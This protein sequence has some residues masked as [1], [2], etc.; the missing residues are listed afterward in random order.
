MMT[1][2]RKI[3]LFRYLQVHS[4]FD[5]E[6]IKS[7][8]RLKDD[9]KE[10]KLIPINRFG[11]NINENCIFTL[12]LPDPTV[13]D[14]S[15]RLFFLSLHSSCVTF[16]LNGIKPVPILDVGTSLL[17]KRTTCELAH[18][19]KCN[20]E[21]KISESFNLR[22]YVYASLEDLTPSF[23]ERKY[24][25]SP[26]LNSSFDI[27]MLDENPLLSFIGYSSNRLSRR[28]MYK[29][30]IKIM[31]MHFINS[32]S[33]QWTREKI[34]S[35]EY[36]INKAIKLIYSCIQSKL[37]KNIYL[38]N[39]KILHLAWI[40]QIDKKV[41]FKKRYE[42]TKSSTSINHSFQILDMPT[43]LLA[44]EITLI[45]TNLFLSLR[46]EELARL[47]F[48]PSSVNSITCPN[49]CQL[50]KFYLKI[51]HLVS[52]QIVQS[53]LRKQRVKVILKVIEWADECYKKNNKHSASA[54]ISGLLSPPVVRLKATWR[55]LRE[56]Y[57]QYIRKLEEFQNISHCLQDITEIPLLCDILNV[58]RA[59]SQYRP[60]ETWN[61]WKRPINIPNRISIN[62][63]AKRSAECEISKG[64][65]MER[66]V[67][68]LINEETEEISHTISKPELSFQ[69]IQHSP[70]CTFNLL[71]CCARY[72]K[73]YN[74][75]YRRI[76]FYLEKLH[77]KLTLYKI[78]SDSYVRNF[79]L[80]SK[81][82][83][84]IWKIS[85]ES[86]PPKKHDC[87][88]NS[89]LLDLTK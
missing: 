85:F 73:S 49:L 75:T 25:L 28:L 72:P 47:I 53:N 52:Y 12:S 23:I 63:S 48:K 24:Y 19:R 67:Q 13:P 69:R 20:S 29:D 40:N 70:P 39:N 77:Y 2:L 14:I 15:D 22:S 58:Y 43:K 18:L 57:P 41:F 37:E 45:D 84:D 9:Y 62:Y 64:C 66:T 60:I 80:N 30:R 26:T 3:F 27:W 44:N 4:Y 46:A 56:E 35:I 65:L 17:M 54:I 68:D 51:S 6:K 1:L 32:T 78:S 42:L 10:H 83:K 86:E 81:Y 5:Y 55:N 87:F 76:N 7:Y 31:R 16:P 50:L 33:K 74:E 59:T 11:Q 36:K 79:L 71:E 82:S 88:C 21:V 61:T 34:Q 8:S 38:K 89:K